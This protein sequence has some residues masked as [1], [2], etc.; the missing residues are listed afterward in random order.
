MKS[1]FIVIN[2][3]RGGD[4]HGIDETKA[5]GHAAPVN[6]LLDLRRDVDEAAP[7][8]HFEPKMFRERFQ[9]VTVS[10]KS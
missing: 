4:V 2:K 6:E 1:G 3:D 5:F 8:R 7:G 10:A 9:W